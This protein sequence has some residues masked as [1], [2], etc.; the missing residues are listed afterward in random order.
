[1]GTTRLR[2]AINERIDHLLPAAGIGDTV[3]KGWQLSIW[4]RQR[5]S[6]VRTHEERAGCCAK[7]QGTVP[8]N[9]DPVGQ[10]LHRHEAT[11]PMTS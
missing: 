2:S 7:G 11:T 10:L 1:M 8:V 9:D 3:A 5:S 6:M 4:L